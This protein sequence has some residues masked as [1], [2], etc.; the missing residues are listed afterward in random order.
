MVKPASVTAQPLQ[1]A[2]ASSAPLTR[3]FQRLEESNARFES[4]RQVVPALLFQQRRPGPVDSE[5]WSLLA[6]NAAVAAK[7]RHVK[8]LLDKALLEAGWPVVAIR[9]KVQQ[10]TL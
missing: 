9:I 5:G 3:L 10:R 6:A 8:P 7:L 1:Q 2:M 4:V